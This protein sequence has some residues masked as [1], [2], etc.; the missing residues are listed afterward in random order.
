MAI[1]QK[2]IGGHVVTYDDETNVMLSYEITDEYK[3]KKEEATLEILSKKDEFKQRGS[4]VVKKEFIDNWNTLIDNSL[5]D[6]DQVWYNGVSIE[7][8]LECMEKLSQGADIE[9]AYKPIDIEN[10]DSPCIYFDMHLSGWQNN[11]VTSIVSS[12]HERG[13]EFSDYRNNFVTNKTTPT[14]KVKKPN[15][16]SN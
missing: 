4:A 1:K 10:P 5:S 2:I 6:L 11:S 12:Y 16:N 7:A 9:E 14:Q 8:S 15:K 3:Q 13:E